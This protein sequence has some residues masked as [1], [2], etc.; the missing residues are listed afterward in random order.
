MTTSDQGLG[1]LL[2]LPLQLDE[3]RLEGL[4]TTVPSG[5]T[6]RTTVV[7]LAGAGAVGRGED[8]NY[9]A[10]EQEAFQAAGPPAVPTGRMSL[11][12]FSAAMDAVALF[13]GAP[14]QE[15]YRDYRRWAFESAAL[16]L[17][18]RQAGRSLASVLERAPRPLRFCASMGLG[19]P[20]RLDRPRALRELQPALGFKLDAEPEWDDAFVASLADLG[21]VCVVDLKGAYTGT[22]VDTPADPELAARLARLLPDAY[23]ED[24]HRTPEVLAAL[25]PHRDRVAWDAP[26]H[27]VADVAALPFRPR[28]LNIKPSRSGTLAKLFGLY[29]LCADEGITTYGGGQFELGV[30]REQVQRLAAIF[31]PDGPNDTAPGI[32]NAPE[33]PDALPASPLPVP[34]EAAGL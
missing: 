11:G 3:C 8:V 23:I 22:V 28:V 26:I 31:H 13:D 6:R 5:W 20:P 25:E 14:E 30:G 33:L 29:A 19:K 15:A 16:D 12:D 21:G 2:D 24:P 32:Y 18:L 1:R 7:C 9:T 10:S 27:S 4:A 17:A 34:A